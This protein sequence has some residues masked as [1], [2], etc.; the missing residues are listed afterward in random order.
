MKTIESKL[1]EWVEIDSVFLETHYWLLEE[2]ISGSY[3]KAL[4]YCGALISKA[5]E[6]MEPVYP[7]LEDE[8]PPS[9]TIIGHVYLL[10]AERVL[11]QFALK[12]S[13]RAMKKLV[14][15]Y[16]DAFEL[17]YTQNAEFWL[18]Q[19][20]NAGGKKYDKLKCN[21]RKFDDYDLSWMYKD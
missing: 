16:Y 9:C 19:Y 12:G 14:A 17:P 1:I 20:K 21:Q 4:A 11:H 7:G 3:S 5:F 13:K 2:A 8:Y 18:K 6:L 10:H 15:L